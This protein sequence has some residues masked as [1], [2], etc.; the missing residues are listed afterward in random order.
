MTHLSVSFQNELN[1]FDCQ[2][3][4]LFSDKCLA[5]AP[6]NFHHFKSIIQPSGAME[7]TSRELI[8]HIRL[9]FEVSWKTDHSVSFQKERNA[10]DCQIFFL[11]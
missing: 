9:R 6:K 4:L 1:A 11:F 3:F 10:F 5:I 2:I 8:V 7:S